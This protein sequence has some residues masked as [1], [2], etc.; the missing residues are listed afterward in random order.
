[1]RTDVRGWRE[2]ARAKVESTGGRG[3]KM[4]L[5][6]G[7]VGSMGHDGSGTRRDAGAFLD[8]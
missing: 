6:E 4:K 5:D 1:M 7:P 2:M 8:C 3:E